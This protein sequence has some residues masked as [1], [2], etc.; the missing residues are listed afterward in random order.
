MTLQAKWKK[1]VIRGV[2][3]T[4]FYYTT[5]LIQRLLLHVWEIKSVK[6]MEP[7]KL[8]MPKNCWHLILL[9]VI[10]SIYYMKKFFYFRNANTN[11]STKVVC[12]TDPTLLGVK[13]SCLD[14]EYSF[15][16]RIARYSFSGNRY[17]QPFCFNN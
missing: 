1:I 4:R 16:I 2:V 9:N 8:K 10:L 11:S 17:I 6:W 12:K 15:I 7:K 3:L 14:D 5:L 13:A